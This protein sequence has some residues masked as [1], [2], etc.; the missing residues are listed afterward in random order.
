LKYR[1]AHISDLHFGRGEPHDAAVRRAL[2]S[3]ASVKADRVVITGDLT[4]RGQPEELLAIRQ[5]LESTGVAGNDRLTLIPGN[6][7]LFGFF[8]RH[9][10]SGKDLLAGLPKVPRTAVQSYRFGLA[11]YTAALESFRYFFQ[12]WCPPIPGCVDIARHITLVVVESNYLPNITNNLSCSL[13]HIDLDELTT[14]LS[15]HTGRRIQVLVMHHHF[16]SLGTVAG[17]FG[18]VTARSMRLLNDHEVID[19]IQKAKIKLVLHGHFHHSED[20]ILPGCPARF[21]NSGD[22]RRWHLI[23][24]DDDEISIRMQCPV[25]GEGNT[26]KEKP[27]ILAWSNSLNRTRII[28]RVKI[29]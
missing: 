28:S 29:T 14:V 20:Y 26:G 7:D 8:F 5:L 9:F 6:H 22:F 25:D 1:I 17:Y 24:I 3:V 18:K 2:E 27:W 10:H 15:G 23:E 11:E 16:E 13:G 19:V 12:R 4:E 21:V